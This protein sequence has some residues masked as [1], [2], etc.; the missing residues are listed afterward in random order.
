ME[1]MNN[2][3]KIHTKHLCF[4]TVRG[5]ELLANKAKCVNQPHIIKLRYITKK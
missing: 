2:L 1:Q 4:G 5:L 3:K